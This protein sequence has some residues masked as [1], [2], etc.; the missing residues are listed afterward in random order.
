MTFELLR[1]TTLH[2]GKHPNMNQNNSNNI[3]VSIPVV[4][5]NLFQ[6]HSKN[7]CKVGISDRMRSRMKNSNEINC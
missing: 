6:F 1:C 3:C 7:L 5:Q 2:L 4:K